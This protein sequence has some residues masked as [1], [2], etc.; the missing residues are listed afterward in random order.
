MELKASYELH[1]ICNKFFSIPSSSALFTCSVNL[2]WTMI[3]AFECI[4]LS[5]LLAIKNWHMPQ[6]CSHDLLKCNFLHLLKSQQTCATVS[7]ELHAPSQGQQLFQNPH[8]PSPWPHL[9]LLLQP[10]RLSP[11]LKHESACSFQQS[12]FPLPFISFRPSP[13][14][15]LSLCLP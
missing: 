12:M 6:T 1:E 5:L 13:T 10:C 7:S 3:M 2:A 8:S 11:T 9:F 4:L 14:Q 15:M